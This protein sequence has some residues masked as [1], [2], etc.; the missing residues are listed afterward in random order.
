MALSRGKSTITQPIGASARPAGLTARMTSSGSPGASGGVTAV[1][2]ANPSGLLRIQG[3][4]SAVD[5]VSPRR[6]SHGPRE[7]AAGPE[8]NAGMNTID[9]VG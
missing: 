2:P 4:A 9:S 8:G 5:S 3:W 1:V 7:T 6:C